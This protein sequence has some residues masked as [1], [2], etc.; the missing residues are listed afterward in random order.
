MIQ[1]V[2]TEAASGPLLL[3]D[4]SGYSGGCTACSRVGDLERKFVLHAGSYVVQSIG[5]GRELV[6]PEVV[7]PHRLLTNHAAELVD[8]R[9]Y[10]LITEAAAARLALPPGGAWELTETDG[11]DAPI[12]ARIYALR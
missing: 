2:Q 5:G 3:A 4:I 6:G 10:A 12:A 8:H 11:H 7:I 1:P 9:A